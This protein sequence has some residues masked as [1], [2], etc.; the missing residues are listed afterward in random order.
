M[1]AT[2]TLI[3]LIVCVVAAPAA[4]VL[5]QEYVGSTSCTGAPANTLACNN[6]Q[7]CPSTNGGLASITTCDSTT[8]DDTTW[9][10]Q[11]FSGAT[12][13]QAADLVL[14]ATSSGSG[15]KTFTGVPDYSFRLFCSRG[16]ACFSGD[17][18]VRLEDGSTKHMSEL[19]IGDRVL[20]FDA[21]GEPFYDRVFRI[22]HYQPG[23]ANARVLRIVA[24]DGRSVDVSATHYVHANGALITADQVRAGDR[25]YRVDETAAEE[26]RVADV[27][28]AEAADG[29][30]NVHT[31]S[32][33]IVVNGFAASHFTRSSMWQF[34]SVAPMWYRARDMAAPLLGVQDAKAEFHADK[35]KP[36]RGHWAAIAAVRDASNEKQKRRTEIADAE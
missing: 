4:T 8:T 1:H 32:S 35:S 12:S 19:E 7:C 15:C 17:A 30:Y 6:D 18:T 25:V 28:D 24:D 21:S 16:S 5:V 14:D 10:L 3:A 26:V 20:A 22:T 31:L 29:L 11:I 36:G 33:N 34:R 23:P 27:F 2:S 9:R 13:C